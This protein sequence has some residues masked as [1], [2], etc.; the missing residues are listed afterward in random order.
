MMR[1]FWFAHFQ[2]EILFSVH[3]YFYHLQ[4]NRLFLGGV[5][6]SH[7]TYPFKGLK[8]YFRERIFLHVVR[9]FQD[10]SEY[11]GLIVNDLKAPLK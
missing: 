10:K 3:N 2:S 8:T 1:I 5:R 9:S 7:R 4:Q 6:Y 11:E